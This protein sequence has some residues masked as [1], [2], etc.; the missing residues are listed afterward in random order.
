MAESAR[1]DP[2]RHPGN[3]AFGRYDNEVM[4]AGSDA[5]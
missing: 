1:G 3:G 2:D 4:A 5:G